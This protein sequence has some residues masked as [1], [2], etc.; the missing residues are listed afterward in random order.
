MSVHLLNVKGVG[1]I[2]FGLDWVR[3]SRF[4]SPD[5]RIKKDAAAFKA[6]WLY[7]NKDSKQD[8]VYFTL[9]GKSDTKQKPAAASTIITYLVDK[10][11]FV[12]FQ[13][14]SDD[15]YW[16]IAITEGAP[17]YRKGSGNEWNVVD[18]ATGKEKARD[19]LSRVLLSLADDIPVYTNAIDV[20]QPVIRS[21]AVFELDVI[22]KIKN[23]KKKEAK[24]AYFSS[25]SD[26]KYWKFIIPFVLA[27]GGIAYY[28]STEMD[29]SEKARRARVEQ[30]NQMKLRKEQLASEVETNLNA[31]REVV[32][33]TEEIFNFLDTVP[34][35]VEG[36]LAKEITCDSNLCIIDFAGSNFT[37]WIGYERSK[38]VAWPSPDTSPQINA[39]KQ[40][41]PVGSEAFE[42]R[43]IEGLAEI[44]KIVFDLGNLAQLA[45]V[46]E[47]T[48]TIKDAPV[49]IA[50][51]EDDKWIP[52]QLGITASGPAHLA[53]SFIARLP[54]NTGLES[55]KFALQETATFEFHGYVYAKK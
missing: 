19:F 29:S 32:A 27:A 23:I 16:V 18:V 17:A 13:K 12:A 2:A 51:T 26:K 49:P 55:L 28:V 30:A 39:V 10:P 53:K 14:I 48:L 33:R 9:L 22:E 40:Q 11:S 21:H 47:V 43:D 44:N 7:Y 8:T 20:V 52:R 54:K 45:R 15:L 34:K 50:G 31:K 24:S 37:T 42:K 3:V 6:R 1:P 5:S 36:W 38:P 46:A 35:Q 25:Y 41:V 4:D